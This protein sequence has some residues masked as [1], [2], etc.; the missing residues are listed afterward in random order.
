MINQCFLADILSFKPVFSGTGI[1]LIS[2][3]CISSSEKRNFSKSQFEILI[4]NINLLR[5]SHKNLKDFRTSWTRQRLDQTRPYVKFWS[6][7]INTILVRVNCTRKTLMGIQLT[8]LEQSL[9][10]NKYINSITQMHPNWLSQE[11]I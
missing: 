3:G 1:F 10:I 8:I 9:N 4:K 5:S 6:G 11:M 7:K 2:S